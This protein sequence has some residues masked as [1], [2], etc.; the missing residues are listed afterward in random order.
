MTT[1]AFDAI[2]IGAGPNGLTAATALAKRGR[3]VL[4]VES[5]SEIG[6]HTRAID[7]A[8]GF[9]APLNSDG[10]WIPPAVR[11]ATG[12][13]YDVLKTFVPDI[14]TSVVGLD[15]TRLTL[16]PSAKETADAIRSLSA[17]DAARWP[18]FSERIAKFS[19]VL[20]AL[21][22]LAPPDID[23]TS[24]TEMLS[25][26]GVGRKLRG[27]GRSEMI[28]FLRVM[29]MSVQDLVDDEFESEALK[30]AIASLAIRDIQQ[31]PRSAGT[32]FNFLHYLVGAVPTH[33]HPRV[34]FIDGPDA[35]ARAMAEAARALGVDIRTDACVA[36]IHVRDG[37][38][39]GVAL[40]NGDEVAAPIVLSTADPKRTIGMVDPVWIDPEFMLAIRNVKLR[41]CTAFVMY[42]VNRFPDDIAKLAIAPV[43]LTATT[44]ALEQAADAAKYG[45]ASRAPHV[46]FFC[47]TTRWPHLAQKGKHVVVARVQYA[48][49]RLKSAMWDKENADMLGA[50]ATAAIARVIPEFEA[51]IEQRAVL[52]PRDVEEKFGVTEGALTHGELTLDQIMFMRPVP[53]W[54]HY[55]LPVDGLFLGGAGAHPGPGV[56]GGAGLLAAKAALNRR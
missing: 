16:R 15:G 25:L 13:G 26:L 56:L 27:L 3:R 21:Y 31:G 51:S 40:A 9:R 23:T 34:W 42:G 41:G 8:P 30:T 24:V 50:K 39:T 22:Q 5:A 35:F 54:G 32:T 28:E 4:V 38:V 17:R 12:V 36:R 2:V 55:A 18:T 45:E 29:P 6:G 46:E 47:P 11:K 19:A 48:P 1:G 20:A 7:F 33:A 43:G 53:G 52:T 44:A 49:Y 10:G 14:W 37:A